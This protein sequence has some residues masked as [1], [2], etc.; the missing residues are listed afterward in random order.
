MRFRG[1]IV[2]RESWPGS[3]DTLLGLFIRFVVNG[4]ALWVASL[5]VR[6]FDIG[7]WQALVVGAAVFGIVNAFIKPVLFWLTCLFQIL[8][9]GLFTLLLNAAMLALT[10]WVAGQLEV[11]FTVDGFWAAVLG[12]L[13]VSVTSTVLTRF[14]G[15]W[16]RA[17]GS[18]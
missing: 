16:L 8:T 1:V 3:E 10:A 13:V 18:G 12:A 11:D 2:Y 15:R 6:G 17:P 9:L 4:I 14:S 5:L 7:S